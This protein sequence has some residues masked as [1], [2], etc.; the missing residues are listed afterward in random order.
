MRLFRSEEERTR[1][2]EAG[3]PAWR[4]SYDWSAVFGHL[5]QALEAA[6]RG[7]RHHDITPV[8]ELEFQTR[9]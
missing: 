3:P 9:N 5:E 4:S 7:S 1:I 2:G 8:S 6:A